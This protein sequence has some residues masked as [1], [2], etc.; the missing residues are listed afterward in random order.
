MWCVKNR[1][2]LLLNTKSFHH[3]FNHDCFMQLNHGKKSVITLCIERTEKSFLL[4]M[5]ETHKI[6]AT[7]FKKYILM[8]LN[9]T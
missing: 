4:K 1:Y 9:E 2:A 3:G 8:R 5:A 7:C 6:N